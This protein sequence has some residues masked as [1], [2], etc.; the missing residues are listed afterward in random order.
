MIPLECC[1]TG[2][3]WP[4]IPRQCSPEDGKSRGDLV[5][6]LPRPLKYAATEEKADP[7]ESTALME[8]VVE[9]V[10]TTYLEVR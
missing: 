6:R 3:Q 10:L 2:I 1:S 9:G 4:V 5:S 8:H 7:M